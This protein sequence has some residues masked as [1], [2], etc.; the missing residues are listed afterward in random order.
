MLLCPAL[1][2]LP[3]LGSKWRS[4]G[5]GQGGETGLHDVRLRWCDCLYHLKRGNKTG[6]RHED[7]VIPEREGISSTK[8]T[9][10]KSCVIESLGDSCDGHSWFAQER[11]N[12][13]C[14]IPTLW[15]LLWTGRKSETAQRKWKS[16]NS[17]LEELADG[18]GGG[19]SGARSPP[20]V[21]PG[22]G[23]G[24]RD[25]SRRRGGSGVWPRCR[26]GFPLHPLPN[27]SCT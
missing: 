24:K 20:G 15:G 7:G 26:R 10:T 13:P 9:V 2:G 25:R 8:H 18:A 27:L 3:G 19:G 1:A 6:T 14:C 11:S 16:R 23:T 21:A 22:P 4:T 17:E 5:A 12:S